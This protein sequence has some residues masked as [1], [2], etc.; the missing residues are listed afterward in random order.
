MSKLDAAKR[1]ERNKKEVDEINEARRKLARARDAI[2]G[3]TR[4]TA[5][6]LDTALDRKQR[7]IIS[8]IIS[9]LYE[10]LDEPTFEKARDAILA[11]YQISDKGKTG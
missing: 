7:R 11:K 5:Q 4:F 9:V 1:S 10:V 2:E 3:E 6:N 8:E